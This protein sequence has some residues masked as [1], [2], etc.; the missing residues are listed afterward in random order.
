MKIIIVGAGAAGLGAAHYL[1]KEN[2]QHVTILEASSRIGGRVKTV[3]FGAQPECIIELGA[4]WIHG[5]VPANPLYTLAAEENC[6][7]LKEPK[8]VNRRVGYTYTS[9][10]RIIDQNVAVK[11]WDAYIKTEAEAARKKGILNGSLKAYM[12]SRL[13][14]VLDSFDAEDRHDAALIYNSTMLNYLSF[15][16]GDE[17]DLV[18]LQ[19]Y[20]AYEELPGGDV[21]LPRGY[22]SLLDN[23]TRDLPRDCI[24]F[25]RRVTRIDWQ[26]APLRLTCADGSEFR[27]DHVILT[28]PLGYLKKHHA[29]LFSPHLPREK[30][31]AIDKLGFGRV[32][33]V[34]LEFDRPFWRGDFGCLRLAWT[35]REMQFRGGDWTM[36]IFG[37]DPVV[38]N[39]NVLVGWLSGDGARM[40]EGLSEVRIMD[41]CTRVLRR[42]TGNPLIARPCRVRFS[43]W[44]T[45]ELIGGS[46]TY[47]PIGCGKEHLDELGSSLPS[48]GV[49]RL[50]F[51]GE[52]T[53]PHAILHDTREIKEK[54]RIAACE[55]V[56]GTLFSRCMGLCLCAR[57][58]NTLRHLATTRK[59][60]SISHA[61]INSSSH[62]MMAA[63]IKVLVSKKKRRYQEDG[64]DLDLTYIYNNI[65]AMGFPA[66]KLEGVYRNH[67]EDVVRFL[68]SKHKDHYKVYNLCSERHYDPNKFNQRVAHYPF[69]DHNPPRLEL[70]KP[71]C[72]D[73]EGRTGVMI[74]AYMLH[75]RLFQSAEDALEYY[76]RAR[77]H[78]MKG[79][80][81]PSQRRYVEYYGELVK[82]NLQYKPVP[83]LLRAIRIEPVPTFNAGTCNP[84]FVLSQ[85]KVKLFASP[86]HE[87]K[88]GAKYFRADLPQPIMVCGDIKVEFFNKPNKMMKK[89]K[90]FQIWFNT[91]FVNEEE[92]CISNG[93]VDTRTSEFSRHLNPSPCL[94]RSQFSTRD[95]SSSAQSLDQTEQVFD[96]RS[97][98]LT[99][100]KDDLDKAN[101]D[102]SH[103]LFSPDFK[104]RMYF[105]R[106]NSDLNEVSACDRVVTELEVGNS[107]DDDTETE[108]EDD[109][110]LD[111]GCDRS[112]TTHV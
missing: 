73:M 38:G 9:E 57:S 76:G 77:T 71:F 50:L 97:W 95:R 103:K 88:R 105:S 90:M 110:W 102:K 4:N 18:A 80:T 11:V 25:N 106:M 91:F 96:A 53:H 3:N 16:V 28:V 39:A 5:G 17:L 94:D 92:N 112:T 107:D 40:M 15:H 41:D 8:L 12:D 44:C 74:C 81:I 48:S 60:I 55:C 61:N 43:T 65:I 67:I 30:V 63:K 31:M 36:H 33:K 69:D 101:K 64:F 32:D 26:N 89:E 23:L 58:K 7:P 98:V 51:A 111:A 54:K 79:V 19:D 49:P 93:Y 70:M 52:A 13:N 82:N 37:F 27:A 59:E 46:Y 68:E 78:D 2:F 22:L 109:E 99:M 86:V 85:L 42:F 56:P 45:D 6:L 21:I 87:V 72:Q 24:L 34:F 62:L 20:G 1:I 66:E 14:E 75:K 100:G 83:L 10:G 104:V 29:S 47:L 108:S 35:D 84:M